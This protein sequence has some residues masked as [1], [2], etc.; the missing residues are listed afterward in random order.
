MLLLGRTVEAIINA[1]ILSS[2]F[3]NTSALGQSPSFPIECIATLSTII[4]TQP[5]K[6]TVYPSGSWC[7]YF[8]CFILYN[9]RKH[10]RKQFLKMFGIAY[11]VG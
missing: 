10:L 11:P 7:V 1:K 8:E 9:S 2:I 3:P 6:G 5:F 4:N